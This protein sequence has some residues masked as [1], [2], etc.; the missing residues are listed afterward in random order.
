MPNR[1]MPLIDQLRQAL[2]E[3]AGKLPKEIRSAAA[4]AGGEL[5][6][7]L[8]RLAS[9]IERHAYKVTPEDYAALKQAGWPEEQLFELVLSA[10]LGAG[11]SRLLAAERALA[12]EEPCTSPSSIKA[13]GSSNG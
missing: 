2:L 3:G 12:G 11:L 1:H 13:S 7:E 9:K 10:S 8:N 6:E 5:P 4:G